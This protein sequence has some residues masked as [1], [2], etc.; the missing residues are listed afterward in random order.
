MDGNLSS[1]SLYFKAAE[2]ENKTKARDSVV[3]QVL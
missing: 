3:W 2:E 1:I